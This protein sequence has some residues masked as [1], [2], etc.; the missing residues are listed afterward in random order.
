MKV[1]VSGGSGFIG[2]HL[3]KSL[4]KDGHEVVVLSRR[5][6]TKD[7]PKGVR[8]VTWDARSADGDWVREVPG[9][10]GVVNLAGASIG[11]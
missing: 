9:A 4:A 10:Q 8:Y 7:P 3:V 2:S 6:V 11:S 5:L 1:L